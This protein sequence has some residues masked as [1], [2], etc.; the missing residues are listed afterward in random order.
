MEDFTLTI[1]LNT[2]YKT[3]ILDDKDENDDEFN[4]FYYRSRVIKTARSGKKNDGIGERDIEKVIE[5]GKQR[6]V[7]G[8]E[9]EGERERERERGGGETGREGESWEN[10]NRNGDREREMLGRKT[11]WVKVYEGKERERIS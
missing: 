10:S 2:L 8:Y 7:G 4:S 1:I 11:I 9:R 5:R 6:E 3:T